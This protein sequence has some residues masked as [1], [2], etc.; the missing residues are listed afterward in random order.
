MGFD[1][2]SALYAN[3]DGITGHNVMRKLSSHTAA[4]TDCLIEWISI[5]GIRIMNTF[6]RN[7]TVAEDSDLWT[8][9]RGQPQKLWSQID[10]VGD[11]LDDIGYGEVLC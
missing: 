10:F 1:G 6:S 3:F 8:K 2:N 5:L 4:K 9:G 11:S 7:S